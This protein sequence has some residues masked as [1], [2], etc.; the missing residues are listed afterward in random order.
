MPYKNKKDKLKN[1]R[2]YRKNNRDK[3]LRWQ[4]EYRERYPE[5]MKA[6]KYLYRYGI[7]FKQ[8][9]QMA[10]AQNNRCAICKDEFIDIPHTDHNHD[11]KKVR[12]L[13]CYHC[14]YGLGFFK[15][16]ILTLES[17]INYLKK[18]STQ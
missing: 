6:K 8:K 7:T 17:A 11:T 12:E 5:K 16:N 2:K 9:E 18:W 10:I 13:L 1:N 3:F 4:K 14:N 15:E